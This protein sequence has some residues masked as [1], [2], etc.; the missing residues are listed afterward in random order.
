MPISHS[1]GTSRAMFRHGNYP[2]LSV[3]LK[4]LSAAAPNVRA[5][6]ECCGFRVD[7][8]HVGRRGGRE[9][10]SYCTKPTLGTGVG[11]G[12]SRIGPNCFSYRLIFSSSARKMR[13]ACP[14]LTITLETS[15]PCG[16]FGNT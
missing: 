4:G 7:L 6:F 12:T 10:L 1:K 11:S 9:I 15:L 13:L 16:T 5:E 14:G 8:I 3:I 2:A